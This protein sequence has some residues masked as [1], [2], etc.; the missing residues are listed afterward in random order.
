MP[1]NR[2]LTSTA[3]AFEPKSSVGSIAI[4]STSAVRLNM[5]EAGDCRQAMVSNL[6]PVDMHIKFGESDVVATQS[7]TPVFARTQVV[8][9]RPYVDADESNPANYISVIS[10][11]ED[12]QDLIVNVTLGVGL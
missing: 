3:Y 6:S 5:P 7:D 1:I 9:N 2:D 8:F 10:A 11:G 4:N 12:E